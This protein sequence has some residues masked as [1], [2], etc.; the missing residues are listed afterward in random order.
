MERILVFWHDNFTCGSF[1]FPEQ[2]SDLRSTG[3]CSTEIFRGFSIIQVYFN[4]LSEN[5]LTFEFK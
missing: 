3:H 4:S 5:V 1:G 2:V